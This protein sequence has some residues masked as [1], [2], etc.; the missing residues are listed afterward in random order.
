MIKNLC[1]K[2]WHRDERRNLRI[3][4]YI[5]E[6][7]ATQQTAMQKQTVLSQTRLSFAKKARDDFTTRKKD[8]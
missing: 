2:I 7:K 8:R 6:P 4:N 3:H 5:Q 1:K